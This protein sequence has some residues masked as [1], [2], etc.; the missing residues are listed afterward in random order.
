MIPIER[1]PASGRLS[2]KH[3]SVPC[4]HAEHKEN[5]ADHGETGGKDTII[6]VANVDPHS[7]REATVYLDLESLGL[8]DKDLDENGQF[9]VEEL[10]TGQTW[11]WGAAN[12]VRLDAHVEPSHILSIKRSA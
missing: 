11:K 6:V 10:L 3:A 7:V 4:L 9:T 12:Y 5:I 8:S 2:Y 1:L